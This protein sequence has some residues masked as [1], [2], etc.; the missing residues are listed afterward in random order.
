MEQTGK[1]KIPQ[2]LGKLDDPDLDSDSDSLR[3]NRP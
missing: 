1:K 3:S 2:E